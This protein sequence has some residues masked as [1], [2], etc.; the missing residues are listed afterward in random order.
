MR[1]RTTDSACVRRSEGAFSAKVAH[2]V[3]G[4]GE[5]ELDKAGAA[6]AA[7]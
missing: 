1:P 6:T 3:W 7:L 4:L 5:V 2:G